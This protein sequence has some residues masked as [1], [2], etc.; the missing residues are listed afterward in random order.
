MKIKVIKDFN[1]L[2]D[3]VFRQVGDIVE[4]S[5]E[6]GEHIIINGY[7]EEIKNSPKVEIEDKKEKKSKNK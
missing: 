3:K 7:A 5:K 1:D 2:Q 4:V 6:R